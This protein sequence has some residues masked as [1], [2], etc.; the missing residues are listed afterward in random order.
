MPQAARSYR[1]E[2]ARLHGR[3]EFDRPAS[4]TPYDRQQAELDQ[5]E[6]DEEK[7]VEAPREP[8]V[9][10]EVYKDVESLL[11]RGFLTQSAEINDVHFVFKSLNHHEFELIR[12][13]GGHTKNGQPS[14]RFW[15]M[16][17]A[18]GVLM[19]DG[20][21]V[22]PNRDHF[23]SVLAK[24]FG[25]FHLS[26]KQRIVRHLSEINRRASNAVTL[27]EC[28]VTEKQSRY[29]WFQVQNIDMTSTAM[30]GIAGTSQ[31]G[32]NWAQLIWR[33]LNRFEDLREDLEHRWD[34]A[35]F[36]GSCSAGKGVSKIYNQDNQRRK[37]EREEL[38]SRKDELL[39]H[40][41]LGE[42]MRPKLLKDGAVWVA[43]RTTEELI[44]Q[45]DSDLRGEKDWHD[46]I[47]EQSEAKIRKGYEDRRE[48]LTAMAKAREEEFDG[49]ALVGGTDMTGLTPVEVRERMVRHKQYEAQ[50]DAKRM[51]WPELHDEQFERR[52]ARLGIQPPQEVQPSIPASAA[53]PPT[54]RK[55]R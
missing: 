4:A 9:N 5:L 39:R 18:Y 40:V 25:D 35:K 7:R 21:N 10:P 54:F 30:T 34:H 24:T 20:V 11:Y 15:D 43:A 47:V 52:M 55:G 12:M 49:K 6:K 8:E 29:R 2:Q 16:F 3:T 13:S 17:L 42:P 19:V 50:S 27:T 23:I 22:L 26:V 37:Q 14:Q 46:I 1:E 38:I 45:L 31:L 41:L 32:L 44:K 53:K 36:I 51:T 28:Y 33:A 48:E